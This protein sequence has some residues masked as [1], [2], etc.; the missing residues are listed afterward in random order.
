[1]SSGTTAVYRAVIVNRLRELVSV[2]QS[3]TGECGYADD[4]V[5]WTERRIAML[6]YAQAQ[7]QHQ[8]NLEAQRADIRERYG[9]SPLSPLRSIEEIREDQHQAERA[10]RAAAPK[11]TRAQLDAEDPNTRE[12]KANALA[13]LNLRDPAWRAAHGLPVPNAV[14]VESG[15]F[16]CSA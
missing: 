1:M 13:A 6:G 8:G 7:A 14:D 3:F 9:L 11:K 5:T 10:A 12:G 4:L 16:D 15:R 2:D